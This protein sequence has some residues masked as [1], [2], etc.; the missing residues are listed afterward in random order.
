[1]KRLIK[2]QDQRSWPGKEYKGGGRGTPKKSGDSGEF[3]YISFNPT[4]SLKRPLDA[5]PRRGRFGGGA[6]KRKGCGGRGEL[7][8]IL[9][10]EG[11]ASQKL[12]YKHCDAL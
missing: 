9:G 3:N 12:E 4:E 7:F 11:A 6:R 10:G 1:M 8:A 2:I 5:S